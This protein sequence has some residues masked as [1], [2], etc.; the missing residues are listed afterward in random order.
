MKPLTLRAF[1][2]VTA[3]TLGLLAVP[4]AWAQGVYKC[5]VGGSTVYQSSPCATGGK[6]IEIKAGPSEAQVKEARGRADADKAR[7]GT[8]TV[9]APETGQ[10]YQGAPG[11]GVNCGQLSQARAE[12]YGSRN[13]TVRGSRQ[14][15]IDQ[16][17]AV[18]QQQNRIASLESRMNRGGC[19]LN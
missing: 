2:L 4:A 19:T 15:G 12:A 18:I 3:L 7:V 6:E 16:S 13:A 9:A 8:V 14:S 11:G 10:P 17:A 1:P 5:S